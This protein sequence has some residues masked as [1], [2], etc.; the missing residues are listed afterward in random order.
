MNV[1]N[2]S[3]APDGKSSS[4]TRE[5]R[6]AT[7]YS[8][9]G[10]VGRS[11]AVANTAVLLAR[12]YGQRVIAVDWDLEAPGLHRFFGIADDDLGIGV[13]N[14]LQNYKDVIRTPR[15][16]LGEKD[17]S[18][19]NYLR[20]VES[21]SSG[22]S[23]RLLGAG[24]QKPKSQYVELVRNF[25]WANFYAHWN[26]AQVIEALRA[27]LKSLA[28]VTL[29]DSRTGITDV[30]G[31]CT[32]QM[33]DTVVLV[34]GFNDQNLT[35]I[36]QVARELTNENNPTLKTLDR[37]PELLLLPSRK[38][39]SELDQL[40]D[41]EINA[42]ER[43]RPFC[44]PALISKYGSALNYIQKASVPYV[45][46]FAYGEELAAK[47]DPR[48]GL[49][50]GREIVEALGPL[51]EMLLQ[52]N[53]A[54]SAL[55]AAKK[56]AQSKR[57]N[58]AAVLGGGALITAVGLITPLVIPLLSG[59][60]KTIETIAPL[61]PLGLAAAAG[62]LGGLYSSLVP[63]YSR[64][65]EGRP[66]PPWSNVLARTTVDMLGGATLSILATLLSPINAMPNSF[67]LL[68]LFLIGAFWRPALQAATEMA[69]TVLRQLHLTLQRRD[70]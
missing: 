26:G 35:G 51:V 21:F 62:L 56:V 10:G 38:E 29:L 68:T 57:D 27:Q 64:F 15:A 58:L 55:V 36:E 69:N 11:M 22:G 12:D 60:S 61:L 2:G 49:P 41:W 37:R 1:T 54:A 63:L 4:R 34:F 48:S 13:I 25:D 18:I 45:S 65:S 24:M 31:I 46:Y 32:M 52:D 59:S 53:T 14:Y 9:K 70:L 30:G 16:T 20:H 39:L 8:Y 66:A 3:P 19:E 42:A 50:K 33:P 28:N 6:V 40:R 23:I 5:G 67:T 17:V 7:F 47:P 44:S 43:F